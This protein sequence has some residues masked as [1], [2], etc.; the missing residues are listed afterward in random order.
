MSLTA[1]SYGAVG[2]SDQ[3]ELAGWWRRFLLRP[4]DP[5]PPIGKRSL[6][7]RRVARYYG[8]SIEETIGE[9]NLA[10]DRIW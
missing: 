4:L 3:G 9:K 1:A 10:S 2:P 6:L 5:H 8:P 7:P